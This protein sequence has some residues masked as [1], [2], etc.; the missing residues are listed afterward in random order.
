MS[1][2]SNAI[3]IDV[4]RDK[5]DVRDYKVENHKEHPNNESGFKQFLSKARKDHGNELKGII[6]CFEHTGMYSFELANFLTIKNID[7][8]ME[9]AIQIKRS[10]GIVRGKNDKIDAQRIAEYAYLRRDQLKSF[11]LPS[12]S[13]LHLQKLLA[14]RE[15]MV[16][17]RAGYIGSKKEY[18]AMLKQKDHES[19]PTCMCVCICPVL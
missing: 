6:I 1:N 5:I 9:S 19:L 3:G 16:K 15:R 11:V 4:S 13:I 8:V 10:M 2:Y 18:K 14:L 7:Y 17:Q 12:T